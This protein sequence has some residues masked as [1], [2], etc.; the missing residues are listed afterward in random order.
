MNQDIKF[1][2]N[3]QIVGKELLKDTELIISSGAKYGIIGQ[4]GIG[5]TTLLNYL[6]NRQHPDLNKLHTIYMVNQEVPASEMSIYNKVLESNTE[7]IKRILRIAEI[8]KEFDIINEENEDS[9]LS[10]KLSEELNN[11]Q[12]ELLYYDY[13]TQESSIKKIL[14][15]LGFSQDQFD[16]P[17]S[18]FSGGWRMRIA[19]ACALYRK[20][21]L[22]LLDEPTNHLDL[23]ANIW[24][25]EYLKSYNNTIIVISHDIEFLD[26]VCTNII[27]FENQK[28]NYY[29]GGYYKF[30]RQYDQE[31]KE[32]QKIIDKIEKQIKNLKTSG[33]K[34]NEIDEFIKKNPLPEIPYYKKINM[35][36][37]SVDDD[38]ENNLV[39]LN[40]ISF[41]Y[42]DKLILEDIDLGINYK[43]RI[44]FVGKNGS[45][46]STL[47]KIISGELLPSSGEISKNDHIRISYFNQHT[48]EYL[49]LEKTPL[50]YLNEKFSKLDEKTLRGYLGRIGLEGIKHKVPMQNLSGGQKVRVS[51]A[52]LQLNNP[53]VLVLDEPTNHLDLQTI[54]ALKESIN[55]FDGAVIITSHNIDLIEDTNCS[56]FEI[57]DHYCK[58][59]EFS[60]Y[61]VKIL[62]S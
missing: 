41:S 33:K 24:L 6:N 27:H 57:S 8:E 13:Y 3:L 60:D 40:N 34:K 52:E 44:T 25:I 15:G 17:I 28:L 39:V 48:F 19:L 32:K 29:K 50:E 12:N 16:E 43:T 53:H 49:P 55:N 62:N 51:L 9:K 5:K 54:E 11:L 58:P 59:I 31:I 21:S 10:D 1:T 61:C 47:M 56:V 37:G 30:K 20:P 4:N 46:K 35:D 45:G 38:S 23:E 14:S 2:V 18:K 22:L 7:V 26:E 42:G 36:F